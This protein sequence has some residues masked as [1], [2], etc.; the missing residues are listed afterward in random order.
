MRHFK[1]VSADSHV[2]EP[3]D[4]WTNLIE[5]A[6]RD[7]APRIVHEKSRDEDMFMCEGLALLSPAAMSQAGKPMEQRRERK[8]D[9]VYPGAYDPHARL[10]DMARDGVEA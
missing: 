2:V 4:L 10:K 6:Y 9:G 5:P 1:L 8:L 3:G 7:R